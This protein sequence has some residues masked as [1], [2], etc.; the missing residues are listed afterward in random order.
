MNKEHILIVDDDPLIR[1]SLKELIQMDGYEVDTAQDGL[2]ALSRLKEKSFQVVLADVNMPNMDGLGLLH[3]V[4]QSYPETMVILITGYG[5]IETAVEAIKLG[6][7]DYLTKPLID[8]D[9]MNLIKRAIEKH[10]L[11]EENT[12]LRNQLST[13]I[14]STAII[15]QDH[16][17]Q[18]IFKNLNIVRDTNATILITGESGTGKTL[19][20]HEIHLHSPRADKPFVVVS[21]GALPE[22]LLESE[23][24]GHAK[25]S[26]TGA[27]Q[28][29]MGKFL[30]ANG[31]TILIDEISV[32]S[33]DLQI[34]LL[35]ILQ[36]RKFEP[37]GSNHTYEVD[38]RIIVATNQELKKRIAEHAFREDLYYRIN[39]ISIDIPPLRER[40]GDIPLLTKHFIDVYTKKH[41]KTSMS[42][43]QKALDQLVRYSWPGNVRELENMIERTVL[44]AKTDTIMPEDLPSFTLHAQA[45][46]Q[47][48]S[49]SSIKN[50]LEE[51][52]KKIIEQTLLTNKGNRHLTAKQLKINRSTLYNKMK[53][54]DLLDIKKQ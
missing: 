4:T 42:L 31:G 53:K 9:V 17:I 13:I 12:Q 15:G 25:G 21:C 38:V 54:Y 2:D 37:V 43:S 26:F 24:F 7:Y 3:K 10:R 30:L 47:D 32:A 39:V 18:N 51:P 34:K 19:I 23:L 29:K 35:R 5:T 14:Q 33:P 1:N 22:N 48:M 40:I 44:L 27:H 8:D 49:S 46:I 41:N 20:A 16:K 36:D 50:A 28:E 52:E 6:A 11:K 45:A